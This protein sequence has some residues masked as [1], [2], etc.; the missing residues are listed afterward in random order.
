MQNSHVGKISLH[1]KQL[2]SVA[3][4]TSSNE[5]A[6][7]NFRK[8]W[9][10]ANMN[11]KAFYRLPWEDYSVRAEVTQTKTDE[12]WIN[13]LLELSSLDIKVFGQFYIRRLFQN[14]QS[15]F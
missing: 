1:K 5:A 15:Q 13:F 4:L 10:V 12:R 7:C 6:D 3:Q 8:Q 2:H 14:W 11:I 9:Q